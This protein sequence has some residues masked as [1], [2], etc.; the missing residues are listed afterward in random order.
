MA[1]WTV[2]RWAARKGRAGGYMTQ[3]IDLSLG[4]E[5]AWWRSMQEEEE[6]EEGM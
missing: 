2:R 1:G 5:G 6:E 3:H 4:R